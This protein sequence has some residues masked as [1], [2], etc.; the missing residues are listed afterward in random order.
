[1]TKKRSLLLVALV[2][3]SVS[4]FAA[5]VVVTWEWMLEDPNVTTFRYQIDGEDPDLWIVVDASET[6][7]TVKGLDDS[8]TYTLYLQQ[9]Y[10][11]EN[12][13]AS[14]TATTEPL[15][16]DEPEL[17]LEEEALVEED[18]VPAEPV[19]ALE[20]EVVIEEEPALVEEVI[21]EPVAEVVIEEP[22]VEKAVAAPKAKTPSRFAT[23]LTLGAGFSHTYDGFSTV[24]FNP[25]NVNVNLGLQFKNILT[26]SQAF[27]LGLDVVGAYTPFYD[28]A[29]GDA[30]TNVFTNFNDVIA[31]FTSTGTL[32]IGP[33]LNLNLGRFSAD[34]G[35]GG[36]IIYGKD[37][38]S[39]ES[40]PYVYG[41]F[42]K[43]GLNY[44]FGKKFSF[45]VDGKYNFILNDFDNIK[46]FAEAGVYLGYTF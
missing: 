42:A 38:D 31:D 9:S 5:P 37:F 33:M 13:S 30:F 46:K 24:A 1:M 28:G 7:Y 14:A 8:Q 22:V 20:E 26:F 6:S 39:F 12:F 41:A 4:L 34:L 17:A 18:L 2:L 27:G 23:T 15:F 16:V 10:D 19:L 43:L 40:N 25:N 36:F 44:R 3:F 32:S 29:W 35:G 21:E 11:G 45:G